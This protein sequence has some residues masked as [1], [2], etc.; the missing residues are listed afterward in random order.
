MEV[1]YVDI[2]VRS[3]LA[4]AP[5]Q[6]TFLGCHLFHRNVLDGEAQDNGPDHAQCH[7]QIAI[8]NF[9]GANRYQFDA[10]G[11]DEIESFVDVSDLMN[12]EWR[13]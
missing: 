4:L 7:F 6:Q 8:D 5:Q 12:E 13:I 10:L 2:L 9:F 3:S 1:L 11:L